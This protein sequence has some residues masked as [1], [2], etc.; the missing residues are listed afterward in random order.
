MENFP[1][2]SSGTIYF[3]GAGPG[4]AELLTLKARRL[5][6]CA[7]VILYAGS[8]VN[9]SVLDFSRPSAEKLDTARLKLEAQVET[10][11]A[12]AKAGKIVA[13]LHTGDPSIFGALSEQTVALAAAGIPFQIIP[14]VSSAFAAAA[15]LGLEYTLP[16]IT[17]TVILTRM[18]GRTLVPPLE[19]LRS[20]AAHHASLVIFLSTGLLR[21]VIAELLA[22]EYPPETPLAL[23]YRAS[24]HDQHIV[25]G[26]LANIADKVEARELT[27]QGLIIVSPAL[28]VAAPPPSHL[29]GGFQR[30]STR[31]KGTAILTLTSPAVRLGRA[32]LENLPDATLYL[33]ERL[34][35]AQDEGR[36]NIRRFQESIRQTLQSAFEEYEA[37]I[38]IMAS[39]IVMRELAPLL[40]NKHSDPAVIVMDAEGR[41]AISLLSGH[42]G[43]ANQ[44]AQR[45]AE[46]TGGRAVITTA[47]DVQQIPALDVLAKEREWKL[48]PKSQLAAVMAALVNGEEIGVAQEDDCD[49][50]ADEQIPNWIYCSSWRSAQERGLKNL[51]LFTFREPPSEM[52]IAFQKVVVYHPPTLV[53]GV[54]CNRNTPADEIQ[55]AIETTLREAG[56]SRDSVACL[57]TITAKADEVGLLEAAR[58][59]GWELRI[60]TP[61]EIQSVENIP[62]P[63]HYAQQ[64]LGVQGVAEPSAMWVA[65]SKTL[66]V[67]KRKFA[68]VTVAIAVKKN[69]SLDVWKWDAD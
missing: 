49:W 4:D 57:A 51:A 30:D 2:F 40:K 65:G 44:L 60:V 67:E 18:S 12:A 55:Q 26:T 7:D 59:N 66:L 1:E 36:K 19:N 62:N 32:L 38:C 46:L 53:A 27:H 6:E 50:L 34:S 25:R 11:I 24:W 39:G 37:L 69:L 9:P 45:L 58:A 42:E 35:V 3:A 54:G 52:W 56:L 63:S 13:R 29:Y 48:H 31:R 28:E 23:V 21:E 68:N 17:Q 33:P 16:E 22:A 41:F 61:Q 14:G 8:L 20:L 15:A 5:L 64:A 47:S 10:M 43:G